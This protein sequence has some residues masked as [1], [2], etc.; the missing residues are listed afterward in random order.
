MSKKNIISQEKLSNGRVQV[1]FDT[2]SGPMKYEFKGSSARALLR[3]TD[4]G[5]LRGQLLVEHKKKP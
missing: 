4:P 1:V 5:Q 2:D 3:G